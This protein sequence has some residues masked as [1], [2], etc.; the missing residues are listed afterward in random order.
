MGIKGFS[1]FLK[2]IGCEWA[3]FNLSKFSGK[4]FAI[5]AIMFLY[6]AKLSAKDPNKYL[7]E[8]IIKLKEANIRPVFVLDGE[9][10]QEKFQEQA[11]RK[12]RR[13]N[14]QLIITK[15][16]AQLKHYQETK[17]LGEELSKLLEN[18]PHFL[19]RISGTPNIAIVKSHISKLER[20]IS[21]IPKHVK[22]VFAEM[23][24]VF[25]ITL[26]TAKGE[27][28]MLCAALNK[29]NIVDAVLTQDSDAFAAGAKTV[30]RN[31]DNNLAKVLTQESILQ[32]STLSF[33]SFRDLCI[34]CGT[35]FNKRIPGLGPITS[36]NLLK[37]FESIEEI[38]K[39]TDYELSKL[40]Y[41]R[42]RE[43]FTSDDDVA[44]IKLSNKIP[45]KTTV[46]QFILTYKLQSLWSQ[47]KI[48][49]GF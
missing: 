27:G 49:W 22:Q 5:D 36:M 3:N 33:D 7:L 23:C 14:L 47:I 40:N 8:Y 12:Q 29:Y 24:N 38:E 46:L 13:K 31:I 39:H 15:L 21:P 10:V 4:T 42:V 17:V 26:L 32:K 11:S 34:M 30:V 35:D 28:E 18:N 41:D 44:H 43:I 48:L 25:G 45:C 19:N 2:Y 9:Y 37:S 1:I 6:Q 16:T 20:E